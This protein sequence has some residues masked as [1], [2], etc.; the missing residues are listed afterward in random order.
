L[1]FGQHSTQ[2]TALLWILSVSIIIGYVRHLLWLFFTLE[3]IS[4][5]MLV[6][7]VPD[8]AASP[9]VMKNKRCSNSTAVLKS[10]EPLGNFIWKRIEYMRTPRHS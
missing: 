7:K 8:P 9:S 2:V 5:K 10:R 6:H 3:C 1:V 4:I